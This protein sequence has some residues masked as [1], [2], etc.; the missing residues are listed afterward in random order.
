MI[1]SEVSVMRVHAISCRS[2]LLVYGR[3]LLGNVGN[4]ARITVVGV[5]F[6][7]FQ[8]ASFHSHGVSF[9]I[10]TRDVPQIDRI[11]LGEPRGSSILLGE[12]CFGTCQNMDYRGIAVAVKQ[13]KAHVKS[14]AV[15]NE[16][17]ILRQLDHPDE[18]LSSFASRE[19]ECVFVQSN[20]QACHS[21]L[22]SALL[23]VL[24]Y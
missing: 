16:A 18:Q 1:D 13:F 12:G 2:I 15:R 19:T 20:F 3:F 23:R 21:C 17:C 6:G 8:F 24:F 5:S 4:F 10:I 9:S 11:N 22:E 7:H 14:S